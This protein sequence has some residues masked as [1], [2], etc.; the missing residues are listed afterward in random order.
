[1]SSRLD[2]SRAIT[3]SGISRLFATDEDRV[4]ATV[5]TI[6]L[7]F[8]GSINEDKILTVTVKA[9]GIK[10]YFGSVLTAEIP[11]SASTEVEVTGE[12]V[13]STSVSIDEGNA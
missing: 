8:E 5:A 9:S 13:A 1:M 3:I 6:E 10:D 2:V 7:A 12:L 11:V 4:S